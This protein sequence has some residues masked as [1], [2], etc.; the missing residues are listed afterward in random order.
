MKSHFS[1][2]GIFINTPRSIL[3]S[4]KKH[5]SFVNVRKLMKKLKTKILGCLLINSERNYNKKSSSMCF[6][7]QIELVSI[8]LVKTH[9]FEGCITCWILNLFKSIFC[10]L[11]SNEIIINSLAFQARKNFVY[12]FILLSWLL[13]VTTITKFL[14][15][16]TSKLNNGFNDGF[17]YDWITISME[18]SWLKMFIVRQKWGQWNK[19]NPIQINK[20][21]RLTSMD[22]KTDF[23]D[24]T[25]TRIWKLHLPSMRLKESAQ[26]FTVLFGMLRLSELNLHC[27]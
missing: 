13:S 5:F 15:F 24:W 26:A 6:C 9:D 20:S 1:G 7:W 17:N 23:I 12:P 8:F 2:L 22:I 21:E 4:R 19:K 3:L 18:S 27:R 25:S 11:N 10:Y 14:L 16:S